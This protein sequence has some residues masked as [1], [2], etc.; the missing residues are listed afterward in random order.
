MSPADEQPRANE[1]RRFTRVR[2]D[3]AASIAQGTSVFHT[4]VLDISLNGLLV[5]T[6]ENYGLRA[7]IDVNISIFLC[8]TV[9]IQMLARLVH[10]SNLYL[11]FRCHG[12]DM[13]SASHLRRLIELNMHDPHAPERVLE[14]MMLE[15]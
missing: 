3:T 9:E 14:E 8:S 2:F 12:V 6:P 10:S 13:E 4:H 11:G 15:Q 5:E 1:R 7:D